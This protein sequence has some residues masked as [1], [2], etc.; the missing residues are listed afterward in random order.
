MDF[1]NVYKDEYRASS[2]ARLGF[3]GT[4]YLAYRDLP[5][6]I[7]KYAKGVK[8]LDF[9]CGAGRSTRFVRDLGFDVTGL[10][11]SDEMLNKAFELDKNGKYC[12]VPD[13]DLSIIG[14]NRY[15]LITSIFTFDNVSPVDN[16]I[17]IFRQLGNVLNK[18]GIIINLVSSPDIYTHEWVSFSTKDFSENKKARSGDKVQIVMKDI[19]DHRPVVDILCTNE[20]Y[21]R[22]YKLAGLSVVDVLYTYGAENEGYEWVNEG[23]VSPWV[24]YLIKRSEK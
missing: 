1:I 14:E 15:D 24:I 20:E 10:D 18:D 5:D 9:G 8:A 21:Q 13:G 22:I 3:T 16:K 11:I 23:D 2:Y 12:L 6:I 19:P 7:S 17:S 4:Y